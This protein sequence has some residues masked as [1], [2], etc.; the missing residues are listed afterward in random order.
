M[1]RTVPLLK[2]RGWIEIA[3]GKD[4]RERRVSLSQAGEE[5]L[6]R[7]EPVWRRAQDE[8][9]ERLGSENWERLKALTTEVA[10]L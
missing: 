3:A 9:R 6:A 4:R 5:E 7:L 2:R 10:G 1:A 8:V